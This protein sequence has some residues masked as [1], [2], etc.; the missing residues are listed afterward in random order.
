MN[1]KGEHERR[2]CTPLR[3][4]F[5]FLSIFCFRILSVCLKLNGTEEK[6]KKRFAEESKC[7]VGYIVLYFI[8]YEFTWRSTVK[9]I[10]NTYTQT[11]RIHTTRVLI[12][13]YSFRQLRF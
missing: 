1:G 2:K 6:Q 8:S 11:H 4:I 9:L 10:L 7:F 12:N 13:M 5:S 3:M